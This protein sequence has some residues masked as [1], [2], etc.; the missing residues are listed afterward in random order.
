MGGSEVLVVQN[1]NVEYILN[2]DTTI[3]VGDGGVCFTLGGTRNIP[4]IVADDEPICM[5][6]AQANAGIMR[7]GCPTLNASHENPILIGEKRMNS[8]VRRLTPLEC[9]RLQGF[10][11][12]W[13]DIGDWTDSK[14]KKHKDADSP[15]YKALGN[16]IALPFW[17]Y[18]M[19]RISAQ[20]EHR[21]TLGSLFDGISGFPLAWARCNG[22]ESCRWSSEIEEFPM[23]VCKKHF[24]DEEAGVEGDIRS[25][26]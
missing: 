2:L 8:V 21:A 20:Y 10:P 18:L 12:G 1:I 22:P 4:V 23:N 7:G 19:K 3:K 16:S 6:S 26:L 13:V 17:E 14:G 9:T 15:K 24:G 11:D 25:Y 5:E